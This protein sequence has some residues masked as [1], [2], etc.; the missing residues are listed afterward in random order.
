MLFD[1]LLRFLDGRYTRC[2]LP[3]V[4]DVLRKVVCANPSQNCIASSFWAPKLDRVAQ[5]E[6]LSRTYEALRQLSISPKTDP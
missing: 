5:H 2:D 3:V 4:L 1:S 6:F